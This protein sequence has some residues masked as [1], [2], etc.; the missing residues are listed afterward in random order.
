MH[1]GNFKHSWFFLV[2]YYW[3]KTFALR[4]IFKIF[5]ITSKFLLTP[6]VIIILTSIQKMSKRNG[7]GTR[8]KAHCYIKQGTSEWPVSYQN[9]CRPSIFHAF[10]MYSRQKFFVI[11][12]L[13]FTFCKLKYTVR[14][15]Y[16]LGFLFTCRV[17]ILF[18]HTFASWA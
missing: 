15:V 9:F 3:Q 18:T 11:T 14:K 12:P 16:I 13:F 1:F 7:Q 17:F 8:K 6:L 4:K 5:R 2:G 10:C